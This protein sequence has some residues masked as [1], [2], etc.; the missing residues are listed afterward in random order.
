MDKHNVFVPPDQRANFQALS[1][2]YPNMKTWLSERQSRKD[3]DIAQ[4]TV[5]LEASIKML[6]EDRKV[7]GNQAMDEVFLE[8]TP[9]GMNPDSEVMKRLTELDQ[10]AEDMKA[11]ADKVQR[12]QKLF[13]KHDTNSSGVVERFEEMKDVVDDIRLKKK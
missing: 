4:Y 9:E 3:E 2:E 13:N 5:M 10:T 6:H 11:T 7:A 8:Y 12:Q 1:A